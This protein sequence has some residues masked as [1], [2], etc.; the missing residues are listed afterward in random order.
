M[1]TRRYVGAALL[2]MYTHDM[3]DIALIC[4]SRV[5]VHMTCHDMTRW[6]YHRAYIMRITHAHAYPSDSDVRR[7]HI[8]YAALTPTPIQQTQAHAHARTALPLVKGVH[9]HGASYGAAHA[10]HGT[11]QV[12]YMCERGHVHM[13]V[14][15]SNNTHERRM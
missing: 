9:R 5:Y 10:T 11:V 14:H 2:D 7:H 4:G 15:V 12:I 3:Y 6:M 13:H 1:A 8:T